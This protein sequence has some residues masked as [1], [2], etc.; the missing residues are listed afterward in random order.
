MSSLPESWKTLEVALNNSNPSGIVSMESVL[1][2]LLNEEMQKI[3][4]SEMSLKK[5]K[6]Q[7]HW[8]M[9]TLQKEKDALSNQIQIEI[10]FAII[11]KNWVIS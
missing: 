8:Q 2:S 11:A 5:R 4:S 7:I 3:N 9:S 10:S 1:S 6:M